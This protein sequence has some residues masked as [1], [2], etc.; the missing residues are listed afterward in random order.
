MCVKLYQPA[1]HGTGEAAV[2]THI[3][4]GCQVN[5]SLGD[6]WNAYQFEQSTAWETS[7]AA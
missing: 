2:M 6:R 1:L 7:E 4:A 3:K 5:R